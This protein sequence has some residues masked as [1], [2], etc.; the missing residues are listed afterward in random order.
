MGS[1]APVFGGVSA[2]AHAGY[3]NIPSKALVST[4]APAA[5]VFATGRIVRRQRR[6]TGTEPLGLSAYPLPRPSGISGMLSR[7]SIAVTFGAAATPE[8][9]QLV[10]GETS[11][12]PR[13]RKGEGKGFRAC[14]I[15]SVHRS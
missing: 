2:A 10:T 15:S 3:R 4:T 8:H 7:S 13:P 1:S 9:N 11:N 14:K 5:C 6:V 12:L